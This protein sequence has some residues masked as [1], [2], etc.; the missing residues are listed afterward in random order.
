MS[1][2]EAAQDQLKRAGI[3]LV[4][5]PVDHPTYMAQ[6]R[7]DLS[8]VVLYQAVR[9]PVAD[10]YLTQFFHSKSTVGTPSG[11]VNFAHCNVADSEIEQA[12]T[13]TDPAK[14]KLLW[15]E[16]QRKIIEAVC[17]VPVI[18]NL[19]LWA[20]NTRVDLGYELTGSLNL[21]PPVTEKTVVK[22]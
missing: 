17:A 6:I 11:V 22:D 1:T 7:K 2:V 9:F 14:Q 5:E 13:E 19:Q 4:I 12:R 8:P 16:A 3:S 21:A 20:Y 10:V 18:E 15:K